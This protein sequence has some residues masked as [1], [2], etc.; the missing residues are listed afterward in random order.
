MTLNGRVPPSASAVGGS[1][2]ASGSGTGVVVVQSQA[3]NPTV[4]DL[5]E[6]GRLALGSERKRSLKGKGKGIA[7]AMDPNII[8]DGDQ[9]DS[10]SDSASYETVHE[11]LTAD[12]DSDGDDNEPTYQPG[13]ALSNVEVPHTHP[14]FETSVQSHT[15]SFH[16]GDDTPR[17]SAANGHPAMAMSDIS[18]AS[19]STTTMNSSPSPHSH[20]PLP[21]LG[22][23]PGS[24]ST[25]AAADQEAEEKVQR[26]KS[27]RVSLKPSY[28][29][30]PAIDD[31]EDE[32]AEGGNH[33]GNINNG[34]VIDMW[35]DSSDEDLEYERA[36][37]RLSRAGEMK[38]G[39]KKRSKVRK[40]M[41][42]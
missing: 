37:K 26:R 18:S 1:S 2:A 14:H 10:D 5:D 8:N 21:P 24:A 20:K 38:K 23:T 33:E 35:K 9:D 34:E 6:G 22:E 29:A 17:I 31:D 12:E 42:R 13:M 32:E 36:K 25:V 7:K 40:D 39:S 19:A 28:A 27:V 16:K 4:R 11:A 3:V 41:S 30:P 15:D